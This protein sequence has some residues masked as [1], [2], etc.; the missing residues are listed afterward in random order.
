MCN[1]YAN[2]VPIDAYRKAFSEL[3]IPLRLPDPL[4]NLEPRDDIRPTD[5][6]PI[7]RAAE[8][9]AELV[10]VR[11]GFSP[12]RPQAG[13]VINFRSEGRRFSRGRCLIPASAFY[14]FTGQ[15]Y[16]KQKWAFTKTG[17]DWFCLAGLWRPSAGEWPES[18]SLLTAAPGLDVA[19]YHDRGVIVLD[20]ADW[21]RWLNPE[22][23]ESD[24][25]RSAPAG[26]L[27]VIAVDRM[28][29][30]PMLRRRL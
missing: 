14:E 29:P 9:G 30:P 12:A 2:R 26:S 10:V 8:D 27:Q 5:P 4:P 17:E 20:R 16:P 11:W 25:L 24:V 1:D 23:P 21:A 19:P 6:A 28:S 22:T 3:R 15:R 7:I 18:F 13:P